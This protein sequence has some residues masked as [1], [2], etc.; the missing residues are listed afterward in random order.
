MNVD[1]LMA[2]MPGLGRA[3]AQECV[4][5]NNAAMREF[6]IDNTARA[7]MWLAQIGHES[8]SLRY[9]E[10]IA[11]G[12][13]YEG[14]RDLGNVQSGDGVRFKGRGPIQITGRANYTAASRALGLDLVGNPTLAAAPRVA[15]RISAWW[16]ANAGVNAIADRNDVTAATRRINGGLN[17]LADRQSRWN[18]I[19]R[20]GNA[21]L[22]GAAASSSQS[23]P[24]PS[25]IGLVVATMP[26]GRFEVFRLGGDK[27]THRWNARE[28]GW[29]QGWGTL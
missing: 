18:A 15:F 26:D 11:S 8:A 22:P 29:V 21:I 27:L 13:A 20:L 9:F 16:W 17:G 24:A 25:Q 3:R 19:G 12:A 28:G 2:A 6:R 14:R 7:R 4:E 10:E 23:V 1:T 5:H